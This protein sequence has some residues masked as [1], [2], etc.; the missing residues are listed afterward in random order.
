[1]QR[2]AILAQ[3]RHRRYFELVQAS[4]RSRLSDVAVQQAFQPLHASTCSDK[5][6]PHMQKSI[7]TFIL[8]R[9]GPELACLATQLI[10]SFT[11]L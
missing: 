6:V 9:P 4:P 1:M 2:A 7:P 11:W 3:L 8:Q 5:T 10:T